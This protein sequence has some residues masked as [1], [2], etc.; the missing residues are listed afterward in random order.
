VRV[1]ERDAHAEIP[2][3]RVAAACDREGERDTQI[4]IPPLAC[5][6]PVC[7]RE[8]VCESGRERD[9]HADTVGA[10]GSCV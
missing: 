5:V 6:S 1:R 8:R 9:T 2:L 3:A 10:C 4:Y 7:D